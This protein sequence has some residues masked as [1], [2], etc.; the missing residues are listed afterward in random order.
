M[1]FGS[2]ENMGDSHCP[3]QPV[4]AGSDFV[5]PNRIQVFFLCNKVKMP[6][7]K[8]KR[9]GLA[10]STM[11]KLCPKKKSSPEVSN[12]IT[13][14]DIRENRDM[15]RF[16]V[17]N[18]IISGA[19]DERDRII[20]ETVRLDR[21]RATLENDFRKE[22]KRGTENLMKHWDNLTK[23]EQQTYKK[24]LLDDRRKG[25]KTISAM[26]KKVISMFQ[27]TESLFRRIGEYTQEQKYL[28]DKSARRYIHPI[29]SAREPSPETR[30]KRKEKAERT[31]GAKKIR[32]PFSVKAKAKAKSSVR[33]RV[34]F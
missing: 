18:D 17:L 31:S 13:P 15:N 27:K 22:M 12:D 2:I 24:Q 14:E 20:D 9:R 8:S 7:R 33:R 6:R 26:R 3:S 11:R 23:K 29:R 30:D 4:R 34:T 19:I 5:T 32:L 10:M 28:E 16:N 21:T 1:W 25:D